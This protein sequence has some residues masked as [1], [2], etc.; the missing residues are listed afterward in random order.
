MNNE[1]KT[2]VN[3]LINLHDDISM[4]RIVRQWHIVFKATVL[5]LLVM[6]WLNE[7]LIMIKGG[8]C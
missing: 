7:Q 2:C 5:H 8:R 4:I 3:K 1:K 6:I